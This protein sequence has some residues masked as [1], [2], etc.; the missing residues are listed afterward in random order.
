MFMTHIDMSSIAARDY[1]ASNGG[2]TVNNE[3]HRIRKDTLL[4]I[5]FCI[6]ENF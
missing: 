2:M 5:T 4:H 6:F 1:I 3:L